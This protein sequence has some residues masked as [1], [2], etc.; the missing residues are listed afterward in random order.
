[1]DRKV[2]KFFRRNNVTEIDNGDKGRL[3]I[4]TS[5]RPAARRLLLGFVDH[6]VRAIHHEVQNDQLPK[7]HPREQFASASWLPHA[8][9]II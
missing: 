7:H 1:M 4:T 5:A 6:C 3:S 2:G 8:A 9:V